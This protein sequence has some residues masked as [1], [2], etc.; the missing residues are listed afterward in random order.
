[1]SGGAGRH[2]ANPSLQRLQEMCSLGRW[3]D[4]HNCLM[5]TAVQKG[6]FNV[7]KTYMNVIQSRM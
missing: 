6:W 2:S 3:D 5:A 7:L 4:Q 1:M